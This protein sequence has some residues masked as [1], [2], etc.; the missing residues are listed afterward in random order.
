MRFPGMW[1]G[2]RTENCGENGNSPSTMMKSKNKKPSAQDI[3]D[4]R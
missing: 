4:P 3:S 2:A 1:H